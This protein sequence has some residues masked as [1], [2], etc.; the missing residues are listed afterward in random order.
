MLKRL[1]LTVIAVFVGYLIQA[2]TISGT[3]YKDFN[4]NGSRQT[5]APANEPGVGGIVVNAY[6][7]SNTVIATTTSASDGTYSMPFT[8]PVRIEF[9]LPTSGGCVNPDFDFTGFS[10]D[11][12]NVRLVDAATSGLDYGMLSADEFVVNTDPEIFVPYY[13]D[14]DPLGGGSS[15]TASAFQSHNYSTSGTASPARSSQANQI[16]AVWGVAFSKQANQVFTAAFIKRHVGLGPMGSGGIYMLTPSGATFTVTQFYDMDANGYRT[17]AASTAPAYGNGSSFTLNGSPLK[18]TIT[19][20]NGYY[21]FPNLAPG[22]YSVSFTT[23][24][25]QR[26]F[27]VQNSGSDVSDNDVVNITLLPGGYPAMVPW[28]QR[29]IIPYWPANTILR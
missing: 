24:P 7:A 21:T 26:V 2:Q 5:T 3:V 19:D 23:L 18:S 28:V 20:A 11:G 9:E 6:D 8:V 16:G 29:V 15:G 14:G 4:G 13:I 12:N 22:V 1:L 17:R 25:Y 10:G 27:S